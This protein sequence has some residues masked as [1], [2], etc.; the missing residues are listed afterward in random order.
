MIDF[1][2][3][4]SLS[5]YVPGATR[6]M[7]PS[8]AELIAVWIFEKSEGTWMIAACTKPASRDRSA[9]PAETEKSPVRPVAGTTSL[10][11]ASS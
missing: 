1:S 9:W 2:V 5:E 8:E 3:M 7:S 10:S 4:V 6:M 11:W